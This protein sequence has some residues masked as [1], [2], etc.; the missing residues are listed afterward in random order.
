MSGSTWY[1][2]VPLI[3]NR[4]RVQRTDGVSIYAIW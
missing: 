3:G 4:A 2:V 1:E